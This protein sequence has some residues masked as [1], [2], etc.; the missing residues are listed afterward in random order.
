M[1]LLNLNHNYVNLIKFLLYI[2]NNLIFINNIIHCQ[3]HIFIE[4]REN[5][6]NNNNNN[7]N[8]RECMIN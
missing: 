7:R 3:M 8:Q 1:V 5:N 4:I 2:R 6:N